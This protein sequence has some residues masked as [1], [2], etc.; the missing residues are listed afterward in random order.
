MSRIV[1]STQI[2]NIFTC[3]VVNTYIFCGKRSRLYPPQ[4]FLKL[5][6]PFH[7][8]MSWLLSCQKS[9]QSEIF[10]RSYKFAKKYFLRCFICILAYY[11]N[12]NFDGKF[13]IVQGVLFKATNGDFRYNPNCCSSMNISL[14]VINFPR[15]TRPY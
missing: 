12:W 10:R 3:F 13:Q 2:L 5:S 14:S 11:T 9:G 15:L 8:V 1:L 7:S 6:L 4:I